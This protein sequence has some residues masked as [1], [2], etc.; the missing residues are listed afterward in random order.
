MTQ[1]L[2]RVI[3]RTSAAVDPYEPGAGSTGAMLTTLRDQWDNVLPN[4]TDDMAICADVGAGAG[5]AYTSGRYCVGSAASLS[6]LENQWRHETGHNWGSSHY[7]GDTPEGPT[8]MS[9]NG[10]S[11]FSSPELSKIIPRRNGFVSNLDNLGAYTYPIPPRANA[12]V[13]SLNGGQTSVTIDVL[14]NDSDSN[15]QSLSILSF[16]GTSAK[17]GTITRSV[18]T[19]TGGRDQLIYTPPTNFSGFDTFQYRIKDS[20]AYE[21]MNFVY[22]NSAPPSFYSHVN[23]GGWQG[24]LKIGTYTLSQLTAAGL[25]DDSISSLRVPAGYKVTLYSSDNFAGTAV[26]KTANDSSLFDDGINDQTSSI[27][28][29]AY[30]ATLYTDTNFAGDSTDLPVGTYTTAQL[31]A[32]GYSNNSLSS[33]KVPA[34]LKVTLYKDDNFAGTSV[35]KT[36]DDSSLVDDGLNDQISSIKVEIVP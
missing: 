17:G 21:G 26:V 6:G 23:Y 12:D 9:G 8:I 24:D 28:V 2:G 27:K 34:G 36:A 1:R 35:V 11:R 22:I 7:E 19:G 30:Q 33:L 31:S 18:G 25:T 3:I 4:S 10:L 20:T 29:E 5:L 13:L 15:G 14:S 32:A 16:A